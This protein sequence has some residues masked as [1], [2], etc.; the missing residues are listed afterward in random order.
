[1]F[2]F[3]PTKILVMRKKIQFYTLTLCLAL[4]GFT[5]TVKAQSVIYNQTFDATAQY[6]LPTGWADSTGHADWFVDNSVDGYKTCDVGGT[7]GLNMLVGGDYFASEAVTFSISTTGRTGITL[8]WNELR[9]STTSTPPLV[10]YY[11]TDGGTTYINSGYTDSTPLDS[12]WHAVSAV[13]LPAS[14]NNLAALYIKFAIDGDGLGNS[15][16]IDDIFAKAAVTNYY[17]SG[18]GL[19]NSTANWGVNTDGSGANPPDFISGGASYYIQNTAAVSTTAPWTVS[20]TGSC[21]YVGDGINPTNFTIS[22]TLTTPAA[23][24]VTVQNSGT[25]TLQNTTTPTFSATTGS[26][27]NYSTGS[28]LT[29]TQGSY[30]NLTISNGTK[31][32]SGTT[33]V[34]GVF[35]INA[36]CF[37]KAIAPS[38]NTTLNG[39]ISSAGSIIGGAGKITVGGTGAFGKIT[40]STTLTLGTFQITR[41]GGGFTVQLGSNLTT[42]TFAHATSGSLDLNGNTLSVTGASTLP[43]SAGGAT[44]TGSSTSKLSFSGAISSGSLYMDQ[45]STSTSSLTNLTLNKAGTTLTLGNT[46]NIIDSICPTLG[47][48]ATSGNLI[49]VADQATVGHVGR[50]GIVGGTLSG[51]INSQVYHSPTGNQ[52]NWMMLGSAGVTNSTFA[53]WNSSFQITCPSC[54]DG[55]GSSANNGTPFT[56]IDSYNETLGTGDPNGAAHYVALPSIG[57]TISVGQG[58]W[59]YMGATSPGTSTAGELVTVTGTANTG[60]FSWTL[61]NSNGG[62]ATDGYNALANP[63]PSSISWAKVA[64][65]NSNII[66]TYYAYNSVTQ[67]YSTYN[68]VTGS[69]TSGSYVLTDIIPAGLGFYAQTL[70]ASTPFNVNEH[71]KA[72]G[73]QLIGKMANPNS[74][75]SIASYFSLMVDGG[76]TSHEETTISFNPN[77]TVA[78]DGYDAVALPWNGVLQITSMS[79]GNTFFINSM[80]DLTQ[81]YSIPVKILSGTTAQYTISTKNLQNLPLGACLKLHDKYGVM[82]DQDIRGGAFTL[83][84]NDTETVARFVLNVTIT[85]LVITTNAVNVSCPNKIDGLITAVG[86]DAGPWNYTWKNSGGAVLKTSLNK[87]TADSLTGL[88]NGVYNVDVTTTGTCNNATQTFTITAPASPVSAFTAPSQVNMA[89]NV[90]FVNNSLNATNY[91]WDFGDGGISSLQTPTYVYNNSGIYTITLE[92]INVNCNDTIRSEQVI[93]VEAMAGIK[94]VNTGEGDIYLSRDASGNYIQFDYTNQT[95][96]NIT[97]YNVLGQALLNNAALSVVNDKIYININNNKEQVLY[98]TITNLSNNTQT[99][100]KFVND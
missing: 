20:G 15:V 62:A 52:T 48:I 58:Y 65:L 14:A 40:F 42:T 74:V 57:T 30:Y 10:I 24:T 77:S 19:L 63:Y 7:S 79:Q 85:P 27:I 94:Q 70:A 64:A 75:Q 78:I 4:L 92:A 41:T 18:S 97:V 53:Q 36:G 67:A 89:A 93:Q 100:K 32:F 16:L 38:I 87:A 47:T 72:T 95:K 54:P 66:T 83:T 22:S 44:I 21:L 11:S 17:Y 56:S 33:I 37:A 3:K 8:Q 6:A 34:N 99:T 31:S 43:S 68:T 26:T 1:M 76:T 29:M 81:N 90:S 88:N 25:L 28:N 84:V 45:T 50:V 73:N 13:S 12:A 5:N 86:N 46:L 59:V 60:N 61:T 39:S 51:N 69:T 49:L 98:V 96:V 91:I 35:T 80:P 2:T 82:P 9:N 55:D 23:L 71:C